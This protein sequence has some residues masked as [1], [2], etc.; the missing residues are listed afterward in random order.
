MVREPKLGAATGEFLLI[1]VPSPNP[2]SSLFPQHFTESSSNMA[3]E[4]YPPQKMRFALRPVPRLTA[5]GTPVFTVVPMPNWP[6][7]F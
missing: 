4:E 5:V 7:V 6:L 1:V 2:P 3:H